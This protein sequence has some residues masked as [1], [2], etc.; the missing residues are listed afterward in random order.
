MVQGPNSDLERNTPGIP[1][2]VIIDPA[3]NSWSRSNRDQKPSMI[4]YSPKLSEDSSLTFLEVASAAA[5]LPLLKQVERLNLAAEKAGVVRKSLRAYSPEFVDQT[6]LIASFL[7]LRDL[8]LIGWTVTNTGKTIRLMLPQLDSNTTVAKQQIRDS[9]RF[10]RVEVL[11]SRAVKE[12]VRSMER[13]RIVDETPRSIFSL[14]ADGGRLNKVMVAASKREGE[15]RAK[16]LRRFVKPYLK[17][18]AGNERDPYTQ[19]RYSDIWR[20]FRLSWSIP[21]RSTPGRNMF[22]LVRDAGQPCH[23][24]IGIA[25]LG[26]CVIGLKCRD[27]RIGWTPDAIAEE[28]RSARAVGESEFARVCEETAHALGKNVEG[29]LRDIDIEG[30]ATPGSLVNPSQA[31][32]EALLLLAQNAADERYEHLRQETAD[33]HE[34]EL[35]LAP[36]GN[37]RLR[38]NIERYDLESSKALF[39]RKRADKLARLLHAKIVLNELNVLTF[40]SVGLPALLWSDD[41]ME[42]PNEKGRSVLRTVLNA[43]KESKVGTSMMEIVVCGAVAPYNYLL[44]GKLVAML[45]TSP[46]VIRDY[47]LRYGCQSSTIASQIAGREIM[48]PARLVYLGTSSLYAGS[49]DKLR[50]EAS[51]KGSQNGEFRPVSAS[52]Y[53]RVHIPASILKRSGAIRYECIGMTEG[54]GVIHFSKDTREI[55]ENLDVILHHAKRVNSIF[56]EGTSPRLRKIRQGISLLGLDSRFLIHGQSRLVYGIKLAH[57]TERYLNGYDDE[58]EYIFPITK[59]PEASS[60]H[61]ASHWIQRWLCSRINHAESL[62][63]V[64]Q[65]IPRKAALSVE[66]Y[67]EIQDPST[68]LELIPQT[69]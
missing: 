54:F 17:L 11:Q 48:R 6:Y 61:V 23:P 62:K 14:M 4:E 24:I 10:E 66:F 2:K 20:Y 60:R 39:R 38:Q 49:I 36:P 16:Y 7:L 33:T 43:N 46:Q 65:F 15:E 57:N 40:P 51:K 34:M 19:F 25:A 69:D 30:I 26:N 44:G 21:Y 35:E 50:D 28:I 47:Q 41:G 52:Q 31:T 67:G 45:I 13:T 64:S 53:N 3:S 1:L 29:G 37:E 5:F 59:D 27:D 56:G 63:A 8:L 68:N 42:E 55:L 12:F 22:Y 9:M 32:V 58:P 18:V